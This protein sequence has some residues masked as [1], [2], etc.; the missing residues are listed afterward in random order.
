MPG[1]APVPDKA[2]ADQRRGGDVLCITHMYSETLFY[3]TLIMIHYH[4]FRN[5][6]ASYV[7]FKPSI[8]IYMHIIIYVP[9]KPNI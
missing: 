3:I 7:I 9:L 6:Y 4:T 8:Y 5:S 2:E 1:N